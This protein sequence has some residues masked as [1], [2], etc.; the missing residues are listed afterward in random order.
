MGSSIFATVII[1]TTMFLILSSLG[2]GLF[3][4]LF[5]LNTGK[6]TFK[7]LSLRIA[8]SMMLF[9]GILLAIYLG[10]IVPGPPPL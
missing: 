2:I 9:M 1:L 4:L 3:Y 5:N 10:W 8:L 7:A 6:Q